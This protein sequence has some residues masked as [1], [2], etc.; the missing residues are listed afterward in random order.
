MG[1]TRQGVELSQKEDTVALELLQ[2]NSQYT[3]E[4]QSQEIELEKVKAQIASNANA[5]MAVLDQRTNTEKEKHLVESRLDRKKE[6]EQLRTRLKTI[7]ELAEDNGK[8]KSS[9]DKLLAFLRDRRIEIAEHFDGK[10]PEAEFESAMLEFENDNKF[11]NTID[12]L[13]EE[14]LSASSSNND[15]AA[16]MA[17]ILRDLLEQ[18]RSW[19]SLLADRWVEDDLDLSCFLK[20]KQK[21]SLSGLLPLKDATMQL[22]LK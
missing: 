7:K 21:F 17:G 2:H 1:L 11:L 5:R 19:S 13:L 9:S 6:E 4:Y 8:A 12:G 22:A 3:A 16:N 18:H 20:A 15:R 14:I 10:T